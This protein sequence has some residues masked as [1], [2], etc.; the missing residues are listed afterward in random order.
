MRAPP[1]QARWNIRS[2]VEHKLLRYRGPVLGD[3]LER[4]AQDLRGR[5]DEAYGSR[6]MNVKGQRT[7]NPFTDMVKYGEGS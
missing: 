5:S 6:T 3:V 1:V 7:C 2:Q 4:M